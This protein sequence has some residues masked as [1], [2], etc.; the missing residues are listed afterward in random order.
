MKNIS[1]KVIESK[2]WKDI[3]NK[4]SIL[5]THSVSILKFNIAIALLTMLMAAFVYAGDVIVENGKLNVDSKLYVNDAGNV[6]IG[7]TA[8]S[9]KLDVQGSI[10]LGGSQSIS[11]GG[12]LALSTYGTRDM[13]LRAGGNFYFQDVD[14]A[15][16]NRVTIESATGNVG[17]GTTSPTYKLDIL[18]GTVNTGTGFHGAGVGAVAI[19]D[20][21]V[22]LTAGHANLVIGTNSDF[23]VD[24]GGSIV[25]GGRTTTGS[26]NDAAF[27]K[28]KGA[29]ETSVST[30]QNAYLAFATFNH[31][32]ISL[33]ERMRIDSSGNVGIGTTA[34]PSQTKMK[35]SASIAS[36]NLANEGV[37]AIENSDHATLSLKSTA[38]SG[39]NWVFSSDDGGHL[40]IAAAGTELIKV[41]S[42]GNV[43]I[44]T[45]NPSEKLD[46]N[47]GNIMVGRTSSGA[48]QGLVILSNGGVSR[49][50]C[51]ASIQ[52]AITYEQNAGANNGHFFGCRGAG[53]GSYLWVQLDN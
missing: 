17:I 5:K 43:G 51:D 34:I 3:S 36:I 11:S 31:N 53:G 44:G 52:G 9:A 27:A 6:G 49:P 48:K 1:N 2:K 14:A 30:N 20:A 23:A 29:K 16:A 7:T 28:I 47:D 38:A 13:Q 4:K 42:S 26:A 15:N 45:T 19:T 33:V 12:E 46:V 18:S 35:I 37:L 32:L 22:A 25:F 40:R 50:T 10:F 41:L 39:K 24:K 21:D 8:P